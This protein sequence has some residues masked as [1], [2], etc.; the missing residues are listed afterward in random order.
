MLKMPSDTFFWMT[1]YICLFFL[2]YGK[3]LHEFEPWVWQA[4]KNP[5]RDGE[6]TG[7]RVIY[8]GRRGTQEMRQQAGGGWW[9][10]CWMMGVVVA[11]GDGAG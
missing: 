7:E 5:G 3:S 8:D 11:N 10:C 2:I 6:Q 9:E 1:R 4:R